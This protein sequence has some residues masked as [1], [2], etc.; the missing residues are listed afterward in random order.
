MSE[1]RRILV[2][3]S[4]GSGKTTLARRL[5][6][7]LSIPVVHLDTLYWRPGWNEPSREEW[8][9]QIADLV[10]GETWILDGNYSNTLELRLAVADTVIVLDIPRWTCLRRVVLRML[11]SYGRTRPDMAPGCPERF[12][13]AFLAWIWTYP[14]QRRPTVLRRLDAV[15]G[16]TRVIRLRTDKEIRA[17]FHALGTTQGPG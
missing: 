5:G 17:F 13:W 15:A 16:Q 14:K 4:G 1:L 11:R 2:I 12:D 9:A 8:R 10:R 7:I 3:G 6:D